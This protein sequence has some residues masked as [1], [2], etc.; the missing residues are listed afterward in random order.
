MDLRELIKLRCTELGAETEIEEPLS[1]RE[2]AARA[3]AAGYTLTGAR[4]SQLM[5]NEM[6][7]LPTKETLRA[8]A[9][10]LEVPVRVVAAASLRTL[11]ILHESDTLCLCLAPGADAC[12][13]IPDHG[14]TP[15]QIVAVRRAAEDAIRRAV[16]QLDRSAEQ[17]TA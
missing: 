9:S 11:G 10:A 2:V 4:L 3:R 1:L 8:L 6:R 15:D 12:L 17:T 16:E 5:V 14:L 7:M 13:T